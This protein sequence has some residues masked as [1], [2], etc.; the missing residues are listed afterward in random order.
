MRTNDATHATS[1]QRNRPHPPQR[2]VRRHAVRFIAAPLLLGWPLAALA[3]GLNSL[4]AK[5][6]G[7]V[8]DDGAYGIG[9]DASGSAYV[10]GVYRANAA[11]GAFTLT[12]KGGG[13]PDVFLLKYDGAGNVVWA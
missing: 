2:A 1:W 6:G 12:N 8:L 10:V 3:Q 9:V 13:L 4:W 11:F 7:G 5:S